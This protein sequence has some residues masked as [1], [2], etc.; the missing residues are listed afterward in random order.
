[1]QKDDLKTIKFAAIVC[2]ICSMALAGVQGTLDGKQKENKR[3]DAQINVLKALSP[4]FDPDGKPLSAE[5]RDLY[6]VDGKVPK[7][8][9][10][11]YF[12]NFVEKKEVELPEGVKGDLYI[13]R[14]DKQ[15]VA[16][17]FPAEGKGL[18]STV[19]SY[20]GLEP[21]LAT[22]RGVTFFDHGET[23]GL[24]GECS[25]PWFQK[26]FRGKL[27][28]ENGEP[29]TFLVAKGKAD[30]GS[31]SAVDGM[32]GATITGNGIQKFVNQTFRAYNETVFTAKRSGTEAAPE[33]PAPAPSAAEPATE[34][35]A[36]APRDPRHFI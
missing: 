21:D 14:R 12:D 11:R 1:M 26:N 7:A 27:L 28:W 22:L 19:H 6:F 33:A 16:Y 32:S 36:P 29:V 10:S 23:P 4:D 25:K 15:V 20:I 2:L 8:W 35:P 3:I 17:A 18:W 9:I 24:G 31:A 5:D 34:A 13:L 30:P